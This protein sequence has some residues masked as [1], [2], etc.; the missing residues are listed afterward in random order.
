[1]LT[2]DD[3]LEIQQLYSKYNHAFDF[4]KGE[5]WA[6]CF[7][8]DGVFESQMSGKVNGSAAL[9]E[10]GTAFSQRLKA[11]HWTNNLVVEPAEGGASGTCYLMLLRLA[12]DDKPT[13]M[14]ATAVYNDRLV[15]TGDGWRFASRS[16]TGDA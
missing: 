5:A 16:V 14:A 1:M 4:G 7:T 11:R 6:A 12:K 10:F 8:P 3:R 15:K 2:T 13:S 9:T